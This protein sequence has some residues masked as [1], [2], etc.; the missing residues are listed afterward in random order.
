MSLHLGRIWL[1]EILYRN[2]MS[3]PEVLMKLEGNYP[4]SGRRGS[5]RREGAGRGEIREG[6]RKKIRKRGEGGKEKMR[7]GSE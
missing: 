5:P 6:G 4:I 2:F 3:P 7:K 1:S